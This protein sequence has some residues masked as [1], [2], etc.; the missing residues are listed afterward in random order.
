[1]PWCWSSVAL[2]FSFPCKLTTTKNMFWKG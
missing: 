2:L 1:L